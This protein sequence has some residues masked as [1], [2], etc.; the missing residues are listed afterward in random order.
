MDDFICKYK[1]Y[2]NDYKNA[3]NN[4]LIDHSRYKDHY[5]DVFSTR[6]LID[7][8]TQNEYIMKKDIDGK[9][10]VDN[11]IKLY[12]HVEARY[13]DLDLDQVGLERSVKRLFQNKN[14]TE[15]CKKEYEHIFNKVKDKEFSDDEFDF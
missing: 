6:R 12:V 4:C 1:E 14:I 8:A 9:T 10:F 7:I 5:F 15:T 2:F 11:L 3:V 13:S